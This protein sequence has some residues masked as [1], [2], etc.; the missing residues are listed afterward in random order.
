MEQLNVGSEFVY[1]MMI[2]TQTTIDPSLYFQI[3]IEYLR[4]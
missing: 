2:Q 4:K 3:L 1:M